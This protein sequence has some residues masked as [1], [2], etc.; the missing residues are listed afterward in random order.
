MALRLAVAGE[1]FAATT[2]GG[3]RWPPRDVATVESRV[4]NG[5]D[6]ERFRIDDQNLVADQNELVAAP[7]R[8]NVYDLGRKRM[9]R[10]AV[11][12]HAAADRNR[13]VH[14]G[15]RSHVLLLDHGSDLGALL[16]RQLGPG[17]GLA[18]GLRL[19]VIFA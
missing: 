11:T 9:E 3:H 17:A 8:I 7:I 6:L 4:E 15:D 1:G 13:E 2:R 16:G 5:D 18:D 10:D 19:A 12:R 14:V